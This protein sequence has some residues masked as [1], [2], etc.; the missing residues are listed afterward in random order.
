MAE[1]AKGSAIRSTRKIARI[2]GTKTSVISWTWL[3][4]WSRPMVT[5]TMSAVSMPGAAST[6]SSQM[7]S[8]AKSMVSAPVI[9]S[10]A[11][12]GHL[13]DVLVG[14]DDAVADRHHR[15][16]GQLGR[17]DRIDDTD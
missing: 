9:L 5:P 1:P 12:N 17:G 14:G 11:L 2:F 16:Q 8:R 13:H 4:A 15:F 10:F 7:D 6:S 3:S